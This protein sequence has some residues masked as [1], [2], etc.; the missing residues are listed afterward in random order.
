M[1]KHPTLL[2]NYHCIDR[3]AAMQ[4]SQILN[5]DHTPENI[6]PATEGMSVNPAAP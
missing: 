6:R 2:S 3:V 4:P 5:L 1:T